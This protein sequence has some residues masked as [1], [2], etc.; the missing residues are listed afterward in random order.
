LPVRALK[1]RVDEHVEYRPPD[2]RLGRIVPAV[3]IRT[4]A[5]G[6]AQMQRSSRAASAS[7]RVPSKTLNF[8]YNRKEFTRLGRGEAAASFGGGK[9]QAERLLAE[10]MLDNAALKELLGKKW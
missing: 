9:R 10:A 8:F 2:P 7:S 1:V 3:A 6:D 4:D 5:V